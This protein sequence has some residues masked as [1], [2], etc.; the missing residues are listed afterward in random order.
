MYRQVA[1]TAMW[2]PLQQLQMDI[3][4]HVFIVF[5]RTR[6]NKGFIILLNLSSLKTKTTE[7]DSQ[8]HQEQKDTSAE[9]V[10]NNSIC[11]GA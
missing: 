7:Y 8:S 3:Q 10:S 9:L 5:Q 4:N 6:L 1:K 11:I 2:P